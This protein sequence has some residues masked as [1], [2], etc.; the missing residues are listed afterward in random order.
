MIRNIINLLQM[1]EPVE[2]VAQLIILPY[3]LSEFE[4]VDELSDTECGMS[5]FGSTGRP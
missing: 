5:G 3:I 1:I 4:E 2:R